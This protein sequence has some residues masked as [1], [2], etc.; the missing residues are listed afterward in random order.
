MIKSF[1]VNGQW[2]TE[3]FRARWATE[4]NDAPA[5]DLCNL[6]FGL[7]RSE[8]DDVVQ[9]RKRLDTTWKGLEIFDEEA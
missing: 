1:E 8:A 2:V 5:I 4:Q 7:T 3:T 6:L 9:G